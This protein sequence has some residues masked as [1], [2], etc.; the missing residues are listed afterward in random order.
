MNGG[1]VGI[2]NRA[3]IQIKPYKLQNLENNE[4]SQMNSMGILQD[5]SMPPG[6]ES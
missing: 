6:P 4:E 2:I 1:G 5:G 3:V